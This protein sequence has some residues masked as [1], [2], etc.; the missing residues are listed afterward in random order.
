MV[1]LKLISTLVLSTALLTACAFGEAVDSL[2]SRAFADIAIECRGAPLTRE[3]CVDWGVELLEGSEDL[4]P[5]TV[6]L[7]LTASADAS[8]RCSADFFDAAG[9]TFA[10]VAARCP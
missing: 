8:R 10:T 1:I 5:T 2:G 9:R 6:K 7:V 4:V 3:Q